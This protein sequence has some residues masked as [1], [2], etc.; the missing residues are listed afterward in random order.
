MGE[1]IIVLIVV[2][3]VFGANKIPALG[4]GLGKAIRNF[5]KSVNED[6]AVD[7]TP[8]KPEPPKPAGQVGPGEP[9]K[10]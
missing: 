10:A 1:L 2:L 3:L 9:P 7:V 5:K 8:R 6:P 4:D